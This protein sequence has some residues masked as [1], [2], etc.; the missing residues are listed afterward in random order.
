[1]G[2]PSNAPASAVVE[3]SGRESTHTSSRVAFR[4]EQAAALVLGLVAIPIVLLSGVLVLFLSRRSPFV[5]H[6]RIGQYGRS[7]WMWKL[8]TMWGKDKSP[9]KLAIV[10]FIQQR[11]IPAS[12]RLPD[13]RVTSRFAAFCRRHSI[14]E[15]P[16][17]AHVMS[18]TMLM[19]GPRPLTTGELEEHYGEAAAEVLS[20]KPGLTGLWQVRGR[21]RLTYRQRK[22]YDLFFV[23]RPTARLRLW[24]LWRTVYAVLSGKDGG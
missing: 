17:L 10:E 13:E 1:M 16:Q 7:F 15:L 4:M 19:I 5:A 18:G 9:T 6:R 21:N 2:L 20:V 3:L 14:D 23:R 11:E 22:R 8:R 12:K 24:I